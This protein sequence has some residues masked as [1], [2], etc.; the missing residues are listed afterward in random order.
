MCTEAMSRR[1]AGNETESVGISII[2]RSQQNGDATLLTHGPSLVLVLLCSHG[3]T[4]GG[5]VMQ[6]HLLQVPTLLTMEWPISFPASRLH[7]VFTMP[8]DM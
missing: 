6:N 1:L 7:A 4:G 5:D 8:L 3:R 2:V